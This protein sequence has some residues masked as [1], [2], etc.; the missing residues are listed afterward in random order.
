MVKFP[1][2]Q[3]TQWDE[4][5]WCEVN[6]R[7]K[8]SGRLR[9]KAPLLPLAQIQRLGDSQRF[10]R[11]SGATMRP[12]EMKKVAS[13]PLRLA[14]IATHSSDCSRKIA[15]LI[16]SSLKQAVMRLNFTPRVLKHP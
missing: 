10:K 16:G 8:V 1:P 7:P 13:F 11:Q 2:Q 9:P 5:N 12:V 6:Q 3:G 14:G 4:R 15:S